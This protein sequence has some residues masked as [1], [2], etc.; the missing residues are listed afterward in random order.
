M[1]RN[2]NSADVRRLIQNKAKAQEQQHPLLKSLYLLC[3]TR[4]Q[5]NFHENFFRFGI[6]EKTCPEQF[7]YQ[8]KYRKTTY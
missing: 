2:A 7:E 6:Y 1:N 5:E 4:K 8:L 3:S